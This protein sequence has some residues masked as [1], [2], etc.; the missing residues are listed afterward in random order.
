MQTPLDELAVTFVSL[1]DKTPG[2]GVPSSDWQVQLGQLLSACFDSQGGLHR[3]IEEHVPIARRVKLLAALAALKALAGSYSP[4][5]AGLAIRSFDT[6]AEA[7]RATG[8]ARD[9]LVMREDELDVKFPVASFVSYKRNSVVA[10]TEASAEQPISLLFLDVDDFKRVNTDY[11]YVAADVVLKEFAERLRK[12]VGHAG[13]VYR[14]GGDEFAALLPNTTPPEAL[15]TAERIRVAVAAT[16]TLVDGKT[17]SVTVSV[18]VAA[19]PGPGITDAVTLGKAASDAVRGAKEGMKN[20]VVVALSLSDTLAALPPPGGVGAAVRLQGATPMGTPV[21]HH[22]AAHELTFKVTE[23]NDS[24]WRFAWRMRVENT[25]EV[26]LR[27]KGRVEFEDSEGFIVDTSPV[28]LTDV[29]SGSY[30]DIAGFSL[31]VCPGALAIKTLASRLTV[32]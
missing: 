3:D 6:V 16:K 14:W 12:V 13:K 17:I 11:G 24:W 7:L 20:Q 1:R 2:E 32:E 23:K 28:A 18:G 9:W 8:Q 5:G 25:G 22:L 30:V 21:H 4:A 26:P 15:S 31:V 10:V 19:F 29:A 27:F